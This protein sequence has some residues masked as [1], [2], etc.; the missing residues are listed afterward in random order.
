MLVC[1][2]ISPEPSP[3]HNC[4]VPSYFTTVAASSL[5]MSLLG[6]FL[7]MSNRK[8]TFSMQTS[9][10]SELSLLTPFRYWTLFSA[11]ICEPISKLLTS[12]RNVISSG[13]S[14]SESLPILE[15]RQQEA[16]VLHC[17]FIFTSSCIIWSQQRN[18]PGF[19]CI[20]INQGFLRLDKV[21][22]CE[23]STFL[24]HFV[25][26]CDCSLYCNSY[27]QKFVWP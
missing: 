4:S 20:Y 11:N 25:T 10:M 9:L 17:T 12:Q 6:S 2:F 23:T 16:T 14:C 13:I 5:S 19:K 26:V 22:R 3:P 7:V 27:K 15:I 24:L 21:W 18:F 1:D 8:Q